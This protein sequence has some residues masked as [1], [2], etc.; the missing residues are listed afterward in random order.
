[1]EKY[2]LLAKLAKCTLNIPADPQRTPTVTST[3]QTDAG[4]QGQIVQPS[5]DNW[6]I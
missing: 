3:I 5:K 2:S 1:M 4:W 6:S